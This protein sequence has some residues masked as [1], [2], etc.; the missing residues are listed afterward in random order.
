M[1][2]GI[3]KMP[4]FREITQGTFSLAMKCP[5]WYLETASKANINI[6]STEKRIYINHTDHKKCE[7]VLAMLPNEFLTN[8]GDL[9][10]SGCRMGKGPASFSRP[11]VKCI[12][13]N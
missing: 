7:L 5:R 3:K 13:Q 4:E 2:S 10:L 6:P 8:S 12:S 1:C 11:R 9:L